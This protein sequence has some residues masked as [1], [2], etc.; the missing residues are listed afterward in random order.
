MTRAWAVPLAGGSASCGTARPKCR[1]RQRFS[2]PAGHRSYMPREAAHLVLAGD[3][4]GP[5]TAEAV[6]GVARVPAAAPGGHEPGG[7]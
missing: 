1:S 2:P 5:W 6:R 3:H 7:E 4:R